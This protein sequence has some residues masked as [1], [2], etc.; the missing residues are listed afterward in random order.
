MALVYAYFNLHIIAFLNCT[1]AKSTY[2]KTDTNIV[3][4]FPDIR[5]ARNLFIVSKVFGCY[6]Q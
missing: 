6:V 3:K 4:R 5:D 2:I 1:K